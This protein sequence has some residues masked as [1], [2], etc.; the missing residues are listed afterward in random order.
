MRLI[1]RIVKY[2]LR[3]LPATSGFVNTRFDTVM[4]D[5]QRL[6]DSINLRLQGIETKLQDNV[7]NSKNSLKLHE[8]TQDEI[9]S[10]LRLLAPKS[11][12]EIRKGRFGG[13]YDGGYVMLDDFDGISLAFSIGI[14]DNDTWD[15]AMAARG[16]LVHQFDHSIDRAP[17][18]HERLRFHKEMVSTKRGPGIETLQS[19]FETYAHDLKGDVIL[20]CDIEGEEWAALDACPINEL[21]RCAQII[22]ELHSL[23]KLGD[24]PFLSLA[25]RVLNKLY[26]KFRVV[27][28]HANNWRGLVNLANI[29]L[30]EVLEVTFANVR[31]YRFT[32]SHEIFPSSMDMP[33]LSGIPDIRLGT[34]V[35]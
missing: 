3:R 33:N 1:K 31:R 35:F 28:V 34:F 11:A 26:G 22:C 6:H 8:A 23:E 5:I 12:K 2:I 20:K 17:S 14:A 15:L 27:H 29:C 10:V 4:D 9:L 7:L 19:I 30:P 21:D 24:Y 13:N 32:D 25:N 16:L 18:K